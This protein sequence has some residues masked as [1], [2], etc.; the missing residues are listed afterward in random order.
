[1]SFEE[2][3]D[4]DDDDDDVEKNFIAVNR[5]ECIL[6]EQYVSF[7]GSCLTFIMHDR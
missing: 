6:S 4:C 3:A 7:L 1:M 2:M 5:L